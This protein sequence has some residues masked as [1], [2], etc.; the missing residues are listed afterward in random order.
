MA[1]DT[2][3]AGGRRVSRS[4]Q[5]GE[6]FVFVGQG[7]V[8]QPAMQRRPLQALRKMAP[9][10][11]C[12]HRTGKAIGA[13]RQ[14][15]LAHLLEDTRFATNAARVQNR[16]LV[17]ETLTPVMQQHRTA[18]WVERLEALKIGCGPINKLSEVFADP[19]VAARGAVVEMRHGSGQQMKMIANPVHLS[20]TPADYRLPPP[21]LGEHTE[22]LLQSLCGVDPAET[23]RLRD[24]GGRLILRNLGP[25]VRVVFAPFPDLQRDEPN[26][27]TA[28]LLL[29]D[30]A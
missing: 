18:W 19:Q 1:D 6:F 27:L 3:Q 30:E 13:G 4:H 26:R 23:R 16:Q 5:V 24:D 8:F 17:T 12:R 21:M 22:T 28:F 10:P 14:K 29:E 20:E 9:V 7:G 15:Q 11:H 2:R 25:V